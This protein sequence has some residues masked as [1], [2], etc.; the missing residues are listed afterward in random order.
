MA[1]TL[2]KKTHIYRYNGEIVPGTTQILR[3][4]GWLN[5]D[6]PYYTPEARRLGEVL[7]ENCQLIDEG[8]LDWKSVDPQ[9]LPDVENYKKWRDKE[10][11]KTLFSERP[12]YS[13]RYRYAGTPDFFL[14]TLMGDGACWIGKGGLPAPQPAFN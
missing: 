1:L 12:L 13:N 8:D 9:V 14:F 7:H 6:A 3:E 2:D 5:F 11:I 10:R 4:S